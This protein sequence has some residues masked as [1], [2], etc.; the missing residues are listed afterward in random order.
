MPGVS[1]GAAVLWW[2]SCDARPGRGCP[3]GVLWR[4]AAAAAGGLKQSCTLENCARVC[5]SVTS[6]V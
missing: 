5:G 2:L 4:A 6:T 1:G 3:E